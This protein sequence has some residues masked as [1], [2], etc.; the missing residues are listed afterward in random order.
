MSSM[1]H[2]LAA[3]RPDASAAERA[4]RAWLRIRVVLRRARLQ[5]MLADGASPDDSPELA[6]RA[7]QIVGKRNRIALAD[8]LE[9]VL[10]RSASG[11]R[12]RSSSPSLATRD[13]RAC[14][15]P[16]LGLAL[17]L[18]S[19]GQVGVRGV[20]LTQRL[21]SDGTGPLYVYGRDDQL[22]RALREASAALDGRAPRPAD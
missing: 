19:D 15:A 5:R 16:L 8:S 11:R 10:H 2:Q 1:T 22:W 4:P 6:L 7:A 12:R 9:D 17:L 21:L 3:D 18:R 20:A 13:V 14:S